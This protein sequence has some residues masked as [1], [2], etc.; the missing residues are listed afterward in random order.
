MIFQLSADNQIC[1]ETSESLAK[2]LAE[3]VATRLDRAIAKKSNAWLAVSGGST[4]KRLFG[5]LSTKT[6]SWE[7]VKVTLVDERWVDEDNARSNAAMVKQLLLKNNAAPAQFVPLYS[8]GVE[9]ID[10]ENAITMLQ[11]PLPS[12]ERGIDVMLLGMGED[13]HTASLFPHADQLKEATNLN[14]NRKLMAINAP[15]ADE[16]RI[17]MT[18][19]MISKSNFLALHIEGQKK[20]EVL[21]KAASDLSEE[22]QVD[23]L[24]I[25]HVLKTRP[26]L[27]IYY[28]P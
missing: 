19:P 5:E 12:F 1:F 10:I 7:K 6:L 4:P 11:K 18:L 21:D 15:G 28:A 3:E 16:P 20:L 13:G 22:N 24:P 23:A 17:T 2:E 9:A 8:P 14:S 26:D 25:R 27:Q